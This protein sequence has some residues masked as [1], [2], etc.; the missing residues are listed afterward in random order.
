MMAA[1]QRNGSKGLARVESQGLHV[2][3]RWSGSPQ[4]VP[5]SIVESGA[6]TNQSLEPSTASRAPSGEPR[7][8]LFGPLMDFMM[9]GGSSLFLVPVLLLL[10]VDAV[11]PG[12]VIA[13]FLVSL[14]INYPHFA[15]SYRIFYE[16]FRQRSARPH[17]M[18]P[19][20]I[21]AISS[22]ALRAP[23]VLALALGGPFLA[24]NGQ[25]LGYGST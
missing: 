9:L 21:V 20:C 16:D 23:A 24:G 22:P 15:I 7:R 13:L 3:C 4:W 17:Q 8:H 14:V 19:R 10:P 11:Q 2:F 12:F 25:A 6:R 18:T 1:T 5:M